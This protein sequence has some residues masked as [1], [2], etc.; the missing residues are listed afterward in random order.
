[1]VQPPFQ[2]REE[3]PSSIGPSCQG[4]WLGLTALLCC[5]CQFNSGRVSVCCSRWHSSVVEAKRPFLPL[6]SSARRHH[7]S[8]RRSQPGFFVPAR[9][10]R[11]GEWLSAACSRKQSMLDQPTGL[12]SHTE[13]IHA[14]PHRAPPG[15][16]QGTYLSFLQIGKCFIEYGDGTAFIASH[17]GDK[18]CLM[19]AAPSSQSGVRDAS[20]TQA[21]LP[22]QGL[23]RPK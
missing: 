13:R 14:G 17:G 15:K 10:K 19:R 16:H 11:P 22:E 3:A 12:S 20:A 1:M 6:C 4:S 21:A 5:L 23:D 18:L 9:A 8:P 7:R 2:I